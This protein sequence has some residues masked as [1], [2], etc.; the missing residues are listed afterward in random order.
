MLEI[1]THTVCHWQAV[2]NS[3]TYLPQ[4][5]PMYGSAQLG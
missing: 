2:G 5:I 1:N 3:Q 4:S